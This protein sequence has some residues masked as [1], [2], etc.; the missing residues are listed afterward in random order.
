M[1]PAAVDQSQ[2]QEPGPDPVPTD[3]LVVLAQVVDPRARRGVR[4]RC[5]VVLGIAVWAGAKSSCA[6]A[7]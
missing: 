4:H 1:I 5:A 6:I 7:E 3:L 2:N